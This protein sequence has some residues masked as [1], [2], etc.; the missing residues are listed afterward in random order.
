MAHRRVVREGECLSSIAFDTGFF[1]DTLW[2]LPDNA[3]LREQ[4][5]SA[6]V[7]MPGDEVA[8]PDL[9]QKR[10]PCATGATHRFR[11]KGVPARLKLR[12]LD[13]GVARANLPYVIAF[14][15][16]TRSE[17]VTDDNGALQA[18]ITPA[19]KAAT[20][21]VN[22]GKRDEQRYALIL[23]GVTPTSSPEGVAARLVNLGFLDPGVSDAESIANALAAFQRRQSLDA[24]GVMDDATA[25]KLRDLHGD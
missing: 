19:A 6:Y 11:R 24:T 1:A 7:L 13:R 14:E 8:V 15:D 16:G 3:P 23:G 9:R 22:E 20:L 25:Q 17:G 12:L 4:R 18:F 2:N 5:T 10:S 21:I